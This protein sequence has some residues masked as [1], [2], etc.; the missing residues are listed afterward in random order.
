[1]SSLPSRTVSVF[2]SVL[3]GAA[4]LAGCVLVVLG[5]LGSTTTTNALGGRHT[6][7]MNAPLFVLGFVVIAVACLVLVLIWGRPVARWAT[8]RR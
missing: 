5:S 1:M 8:N 6:T 3:A 7:L 2:A 4:F